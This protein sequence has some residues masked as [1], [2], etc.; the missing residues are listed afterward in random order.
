MATSTHPSSSCTASSS[1]CASGEL[2]ALGRSGS[3]LELR[4]R[5]GSHHA[6][7]RKVVA[8]REWRCWAISAALPARAARQQLQR[9]GTKCEGTSKGVG[10]EHRPTAHVARPS[11]DRSRGHWRVLVLEPER[12]ALRDAG[13]RR[14]GAYVLGNQVRSCR[15]DFSLRGDGEA[16]LERRERREAIAVAGEKRY[17]AGGFFVAGS[18]VVQRVARKG[19]GGEEVGGQVAGERGVGGV[20]VS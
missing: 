8:K 10:D 18:P 15:G 16:V 17:A 19:V 11:R 4:R 13:G 14:R 20:E 9:V 3:G 1:V 7:Q 6:R 12:K 2:Q 5:Q